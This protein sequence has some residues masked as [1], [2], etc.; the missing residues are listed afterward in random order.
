[1]GPLIQSLPEPCQ[2]GH[3]EKELKHVLSHKSIALYCQSHYMCA[4]R[5]K[6]TALCCHS[7]YIG[8]ER[9]KSIVLCCH[10]HYIGAQRHRAGLAVVFVQPLHPVFC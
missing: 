10:S 7:H 2:D 8:A 5:H 4:Q 1:M 6:Y 9:Q 3:K